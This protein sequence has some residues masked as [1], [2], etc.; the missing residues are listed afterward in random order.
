MH[1][2]WYSLIRKNIP[3]D[4]KECCVFA[5]RATSKDALDGI[6]KMCTGA[7]SDIVNHNYWVMN[8]VCLYFVTTK[9]KWFD[10]FIPLLSL[11]SHFII[12]E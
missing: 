4:I 7:R 10:A 3:I 9:G 12:N 1:R 5:L 11:S 2:N 6:T 8:C